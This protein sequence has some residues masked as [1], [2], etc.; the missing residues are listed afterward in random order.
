M[1]ETV[2]V[3]KFSDANIQA[4]VDHALDVLSKQEPGKTIA[5]VAHADLN[6]ASLTAVGKIGGVWSVSGSVSKPWHGP[7]SAEAEVIASF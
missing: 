6:G 7:L 5:L 2:L 4:A 1:A 3:R